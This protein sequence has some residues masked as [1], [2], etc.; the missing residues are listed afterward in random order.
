MRI[1]KTCPTCQKTFETWPCRSDSQRYCSSQCR[2]AA[3]LATYRCERCGKSF[4]RYQSHAKRLMFCSQ[5]CRQNRTTCV[6]QRCGKTFSKI[7]SAVAIGEGKFC[8]WRCRH[9][10]PRMTRA[11]Y[12]RRQKQLVQANPER[13][14]ERQRRWRLNNPEAV[15]EA[16][17]RSRLRNPDRLRKWRQANPELNRSYNQNRR[18]RQ[19]NA[20]GHH[21]AADIKMLFKRQK[22][23]CAYCKKSLRRGHHIDHIVPLSKGGSNW[24]TN[25]Q[26]LCATCNTRKGALHPT[27]FARRMGL[28]L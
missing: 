17:R 28:L 20:E 4:E 24:P 19:R 9:P 12:K 6:C 18:A 14:R 25:L 1:Q 7:K 27:D 3:S 22:Q 16:A 2:K 21:N 23:R 8:S 11:E 26:L 10:R 5:A 15:R 13:A